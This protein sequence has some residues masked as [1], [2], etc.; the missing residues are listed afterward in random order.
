MIEEVR[1][2]E[3][4]AV[5][6]MGS[7]VLLLAAVFV[8]GHYRREHRRAQLLRHLSASG[9]PWHRQSATRE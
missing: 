3:S 7:A 9:L 5:I 2:D 8:A 4:E 6:A 1:M